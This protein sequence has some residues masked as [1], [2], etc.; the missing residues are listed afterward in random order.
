MRAPWEDLKQGIMRS[1]GTLG[2]KSP[3]Q[4]MRG[5]WRPL[6]RFT[7]VGAL[8]AYL[9]SP[10]GNLD[11]KDEIYAVLVESVQRRSAEAELAAAIVLLGLWPGFDRIYRHRIQDFKGDSTALVSEI[12][13]RV[14]ATINRMDLSGVQRVAATIVRNVDRDIREG[15]K[16]TWALDDLRGTLPF[17][18]RREEH[19]ETGARGEAWSHPRLRT[20]G[21][22]ELGEPYRLDTD[23]DIRSLHRMLFEL[24]GDDADLVIGAALYGSQKDLAEHI[25][26]SHEAARKR[27]QRAV[28]RLREHFG[29]C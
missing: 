6:H 2:A 27:Y 5:R 4:L 8:L 16:R 17:E 15:L 19:A 22:S 10:G 25:G 12:G 7:D 23:D 1:V 9:N 3:F 26:L 28:S 11:E 13:M 18:V 29:G 20:R 21:P 14:T 24:V